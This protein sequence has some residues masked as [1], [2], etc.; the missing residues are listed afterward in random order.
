MVIILNV[1]QESNV[2][3]LK[4]IEN[5]NKNINYYIFYLTKNMNNPEIMT[6]ILKFYKTLEISKNTELMKYVNPVCINPYINYFLKQMK[7]KFINEGDLIF[8]NIE[9]LKIVLSSTYQ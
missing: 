8:T 2:K 1:E 6:E 9:H 7:K 4:Y 5:I 3:D